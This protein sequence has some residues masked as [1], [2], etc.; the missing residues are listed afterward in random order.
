MQFSRR[1]VL[2]GVAGLAVLGLG[3]GGARYWLGRPDEVTTHDYELI[4]APMDVELVAGHSTRV[5]AYGGQV[6]GL[7][8]RARQGDRLRVR[9]INRL[10]QPTTIHWHGIRLPLE[11]DGVPYVSQLP[12]LPGEHFDYDFLL[13][14]AGSFWYHPHTASGEQLGRGLWAR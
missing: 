6:P 1:Q 13:P 3:A 12:V 2:A 5:W 8:L 4:A 7:E 11:M 9:F 14:D 10:E